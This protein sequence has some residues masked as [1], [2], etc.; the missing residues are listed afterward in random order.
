MTIAMV[1]GGFVVAFIRGWEL[2]LICS[3][4]LPFIALTTAI[5]TYMIQNSDR[6]VN[7]S[8]NQAGGIA[9][10]AINGIKTVKALNG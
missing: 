3:A 10:Q 1:F 8:Y 5:F 2:S 7:E 9:E 6:M 4:A